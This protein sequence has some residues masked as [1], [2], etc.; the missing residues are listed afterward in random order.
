M[1]VRSGLANAKNIARPTPMMNEASI[2]PSSRNTLAWSCG[3]SS[4]WR[5]A[6][7]RKRLHMMPTPT[8]APSAP[9][10]IIR[11]MPTLVYAW[12]M[13]MSWSF[14]ILIFL[15]GDDSVMKTVGSVAFVRHLQVDDGEH[16][17]DVGLEG[18]DEDVED[19]PSEPEDD[20]RDRAHDADGGHE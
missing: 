17:E 5:A 12:I 20:G 18:H 10:P 7:S 14:S 2:R 1:T 19:R 9:R 6:P 16:H 8:Q 13:A 15:S 4:G 11:P 3:M